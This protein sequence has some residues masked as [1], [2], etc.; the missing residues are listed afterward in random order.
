MNWTV[1]L[2][3]ASE[4]HAAKVVAWLPTSGLLRLEFGS[5]RVIR[6]DFEPLPDAWAR[7]FLG[8]TLEFARLE[9]NGAASVRIT[10]SRAALAKFARRLYGAT[11]PLELVE[12]RATEPPVTFLTL[13]QDD[14]LRVAVA[15]GY[16]RI[17]RAL[18]LDELAKKLGITSASLSERLRRAE[19]RIISRYVDAGSASP[20]DE[21]TLFDEAP[22]DFS[23]VVWP[24]TVSRPRTPPRRGR[25]E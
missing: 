23:S 9:P 15:A 3:S 6:A 10:G 11:A 22:P 1:F 17:P 5:H 14:A 8:V 4:I 16:Y 12:L 21:K 7:V 24:E 20:W 13:P 18:N 2:Q 19:G 25:F